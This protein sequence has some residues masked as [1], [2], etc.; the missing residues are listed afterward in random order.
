MRGLREG[1]SEAI[2]K[3]PNIRVYGEPIQVEQYAN[4]LF[5]QFDR[6]ENWTQT[7]STEVD[8]AVAS[9]QVR[10][11]DVA[12]ANLSDGL[13]TVE[14]WKTASALGILSRRSDTIR[15]IDETLEKFHSL[16]WKSNFL[17]R[18]EAF[19]QLFLAVTKHRE[20]KAESKRSDAV[21]RLAGQILTILRNRRFY[22]H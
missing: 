20:D 14:G 6:L 13:W 11:L 5:I 8:Q 22:A 9:G 4:E 18:Y 21:V 15:K 3:S 1:G 16:T 19:V 7:L 17:E 10:V 2:V 12:T